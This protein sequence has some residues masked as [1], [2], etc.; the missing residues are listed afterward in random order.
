[1]RPPIVAAPDVHAFLR[2]ER[3]LAV[4]WGTVMVAL[5]GLL[6]GFIWN[7]VIT[8]NGAHRALVAAEDR[9]DAARADAEAARLGASTAR[10]ELEEGRAMFAEG[11]ALL[12]RTRNEMLRTTVTLNS[13]KEGLR[14]SREK[15]VATVAERDQARAEIQK[16]RE[17]LDE[18]TA[19]IAGLT[20][21]LAATRV[22]LLAGR[23][24]AAVANQRI[25]DLRADLAY[26]EVQLAD[27][28]SLVGTLAEHIGLSIALEEHLHPVDIEDAKKLAASSDRLARLLSRVLELQK[29]ETRFSSANK[30]GIG[31]NSPG[32]TGYVLGRIVRGRTLKSLPPT[33]TPR[34]GDII[35]YE[36]GFTMFLLED[37]KGAPFVIGM[38]PVGIAALEPDFGV[39]RTG[40]LSTGILPQ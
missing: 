11:A 10:A 22:Q 33:D 7:S 14:Q 36:N 25:A 39:P 32:F 27:A 16:L 38:T 23:G 9:A 40:A 18:A 4:V 24:Q 30:P 5:I 1:M 17:S 8:L 31:F 21:Q 15:V 12:N 2:R 3:R 34:L 29:Q 35:R 19:E 6:C 20:G 28:E 13:V 37:A 26:T